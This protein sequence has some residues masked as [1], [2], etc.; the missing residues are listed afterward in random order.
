MTLILIIDNRAGRGYSLATVLQQGGYQTHTVS[1]AMDAFNALDNI[2]PALILLSDD[3]P[4]SSN[5]HLCSRLKA[6]LDNIPVLLYS[7]ELRICNEAY[8]R[9]LGADYIVPYPF[10]R[11][12]LMQQVATALSSVLSSGRQV[13]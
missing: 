3:L 8:V 9:A 5:G 7:D 10:T 12:S 13:G 11:T 6:R 1:G 2:T 4:A